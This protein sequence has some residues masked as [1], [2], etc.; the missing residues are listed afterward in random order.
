MAEGRLTK[1][2][3]LSALE[4]WSPAGEE[5]VWEEGGGSA[6]VKVCWVFRSR[7]GTWPKSNGRQRRQGERSGD[8][9]WVCTHQPMCPAIVG[10]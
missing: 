9:T 2:I 4:R 3:K 8:R 6:H 7:M 10:W 5:G 1:S